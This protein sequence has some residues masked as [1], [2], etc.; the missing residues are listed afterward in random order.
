MHEP[1]ACKHVRLN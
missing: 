1:S